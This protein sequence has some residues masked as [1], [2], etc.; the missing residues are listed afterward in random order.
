MG[1]PDLEYNKEKQSSNTKSQQIEKNK[2]INKPKKT[3]NIED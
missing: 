2:S 3:K 1:V